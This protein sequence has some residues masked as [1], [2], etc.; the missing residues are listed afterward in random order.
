MWTDSSGSSTSGITANHSWL[1]Q[2]LT[3]SFP[4][5]TLPQWIFHADT[6]P[7]N[8][9]LPLVLLID[10]EV[11]L[12]TRYRKRVQRRNEHFSKQSLQG[13]PAPPEGEYSFYTGILRNSWGYISLHSWTALTVCCLWK[14]C[15]YSPHLLHFEPG[16]FFHG[17][18]WL[19][20]PR[21]QPPAFFFLIIFLLWATELCQ[22][23]KLAKNTRMGWTVGSRAGDAQKV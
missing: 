12:I 15:S 4:A 22:L 5:I 10:L 13:H 7:S 8:S 6:S 11:P 9:P 20:T 23:K 3:L 1:H 14:G 21:R 2:V 19:I 16:P 18:I 17:F